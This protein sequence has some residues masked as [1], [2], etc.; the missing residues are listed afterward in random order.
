MYTIQKGGA[1]MQQF[2]AL[3]PEDMEGINGGFSIFY[4]IGYAIGSTARE[5]VYTT[6]S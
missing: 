2:Q 3:S 6:K 1:I 4:E 5:V